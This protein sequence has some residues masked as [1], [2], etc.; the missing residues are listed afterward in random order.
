[1]N[2]LGLLLLLLAPRTLAAQPSLYG[3]NFPV[4]EKES[5]SAPET[6]KS[7]TS[8]AQTGARTVAVI[9]TQY[10]DSPQGFTIRSTNGTASD[11]S[12]RQII[13]QAKGLGMDVVLKP[14]LD[15]PGEVSRHSIQPRDPRAW[16]ENYR[17][18]ILHYARIAQ[19]ESAD[20]FVI[21]TELSSLTGGDNKAE[22]EAT[23]RAARGVYSGKIT[24]AA[25]WYEFP[26]LS[27]WD[28]LDYIGVDGYFPLAGGAN[29]RLL[30]LSWHA[31]IP[32]LKAISWRYGKP[33]LFTEIGVASQAGSSLKPWAYADSGALDVA[34]QKIY[35]EAFLEIFGQEP[36][37]A[38]FL[39]WAW[40]PDPNAGG[41]SDKSMTV[42]GKPALEPLREYFQLMRPIKPA[43][44]PLE[45]GKMGTRA[46]TIER[47][48]NNLGRFFQTNP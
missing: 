44:D 45:R 33:L 28:S 40:A 15:V 9:P 16:F 37:V 23:V 36:Y 14:H 31:Y 25:M 2:R 26:Q 39:Q 18:F 41:L 7:L 17:A 30:K 38:G 8:M 4:W 1:M 22:W 32:L 24:Y 35:F 12:V 10:L 27:F 11:T 29:K 19:E 20:L 42:Q 46:A 3:F 21:G 5:Y 43:V 34:S 6:G 48:L 13:R 47:Q